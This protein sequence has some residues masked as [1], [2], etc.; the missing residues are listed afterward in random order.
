MRRLGI[1]L[2]LICSIFIS[3]HAQAAGFYV[4]P[5]ITYEKGDNE[6]EWPAPLSDST[7]NTKGLGVNLKLG[8]HAADSFFMGIDGSYSKP[9][10]E[11]SATDY[12]AD[13]TS[14]LYGVVLGAQMPVIGL[15]LWAGY[16]FGGDLD[17]E[18]SGDIDVKFEDAK[19]PKVGLGFKILMV[20]LNI[21]YMDLEYN[22]SI[23]E[24]P[25]S[26]SGTLDNKLKNKVGLVSI[27]M[28]LTL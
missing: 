20:S 14:A 5:G 15:R 19:G 26:I 24:E 3:T 28:P 18:E 17:P 11:Q 16:I 6:L 7:G 21:E 23:L 27:S 8:F 10:F 4:E 13:A 9:R 2:A 25:G 12:D 22:D 1:G